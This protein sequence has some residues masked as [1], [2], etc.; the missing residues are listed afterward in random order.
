MQFFLLLD[1]KLFLFINVTLA[2]SVFDQIMPFVTNLNN[3]K[4]PILLF[5]LYLVIAQDRRG[6]VVAL[7]VIPVI[8]CTDQISASVLKPLVGRIRPC[9][10][11]QQ[12]RL[13][14]SC[15]GRYA[16]PSSHATNLAGFAT[17]YT[18]LYRRQWWWIW[19]LTGLIGF[20]RIYVGKHYPLDVL[21]GFIIG[22][23]IT[24]FIFFLYLQIVEKYPFLGYRQLDNREG[25]S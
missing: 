3:W 13:L 18:I 19:G 22:S 9:Y 4:I 17:L 25:K 16:F 10:A 24:L 20:S 23:A 11:L 21:G 14:V 5:W 15:G 12:V 6:R 1:K 2:N 7:L 8:V